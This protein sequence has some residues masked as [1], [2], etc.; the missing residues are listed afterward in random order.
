MAPGKADRGAYWLMQIIAGN[1]IA[2]RAF[3][4]ALNAVLGSWL[5]AALGGMQTL[6]TVVIRIGF[7]SASDR[8]PMIGNQP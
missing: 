7:A 4:N 2:M 5:M 3:A 6:R 1:L 8:L